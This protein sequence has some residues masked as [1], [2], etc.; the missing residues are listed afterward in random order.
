MCHIQGEVPCCMLFTYDIVLIDGTRDGVNNRLEVWK[1]S[2]KSKG[3]KLS[4]TKIE[5]LKCKFQGY[6]QVIPQGRKFQV[7]W[8]YDPINREIDNDVTY[9]IG[10]E[11]VKWRFAF[12]LFCD[13]NV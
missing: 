10:A 2:L 12:G 13:K 6:T 1:Q 11:W 9:R 8:V 3:F 7:S 5:Y 4:K